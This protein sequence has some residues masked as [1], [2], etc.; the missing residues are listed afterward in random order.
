MLT[1]KLAYALTLETGSTSNLTSLLCSLATLSKPA[2]PAKLAQT[3]CPLYKL[4]LLTS[5]MVFHER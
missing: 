5:L 1:V 3:P 2:A 4:A